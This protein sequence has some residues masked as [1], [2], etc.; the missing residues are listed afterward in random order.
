MS[1]KHK[2]DH[3]M[4]IMRRGLRDLAELPP[5]G[6]RRVLAYLTDRIEGLPVPESTNGAQQLDIEEVIPQM[7]TLHTRGAAA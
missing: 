2:P 5:A 7:P 6:R 1:S 3:E 4:E